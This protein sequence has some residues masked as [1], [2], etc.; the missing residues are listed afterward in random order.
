MTLTAEYIAS[1]HALWLKRIAAAGVWNA[2][3]MDRVN[4]KVKPAA[5]TLNG[6][7]VRRIERQRNPFRR[8]VVSD[9]II[10]YA[11]PWLD[12]ELKID[13]VMVHEMIHQYIA[14]SRQRDTSSHGRLFRAYMAELN[15]RFAGELDLHV[16]TR[17]QLS[18][19]MMALRKSQEPYI[20][21]IVADDRYFYCCRVMKSA[22]KDIHQLLKRLRSGGKITDYSWFVSTDPRFATLS[23][24]RT[25]LHG[26]RHPLS[27]LST[28]ISTHSLTDITAQIS[29]IQK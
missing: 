4:F 27:E 2:E 6:K 10:I 29:K 21:T 22:I 3:G 14:V 5:R 24:C 12:S 19:D 23:A 9:T 17:A 15:S 11:N 20:L 25:R 8:P 26:L 18:P 1:R 28:F 7:F 13:S 16:S